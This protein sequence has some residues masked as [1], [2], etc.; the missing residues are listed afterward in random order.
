M[1][2]NTLG[3]RKDGPACV[4]S[5]ERRRR[6]ACEFTIAGPNSALPDGTDA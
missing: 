3:L 4:V 6:A 2:G 1:L 5:A